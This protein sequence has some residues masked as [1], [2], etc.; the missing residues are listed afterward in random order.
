MLTTKGVDAGIYTEER[1]GSK[2]NYRVI[3]YNKSAQKKII[4]HLTETSGS[5]V[6]VN[7]QTANANQ[8]DSN[9]G[10]PWDN[11][12]EEELTEMFN[13][14]LTVNE[15]ANAMKRSRGGIRARLLK[16][17]LISDENEV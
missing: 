7:Q 4:E 17:G 16:L 8:A 2:G 3:L 13:D 1:V 9:R 10:K 14:G 11:K 15:I 6:A 12:Q 5:D